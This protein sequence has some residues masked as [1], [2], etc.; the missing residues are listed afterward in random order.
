MNYYFYKSRKLMNISE[1]G[2]IQQSK[3][4]CNIPKAHKSEIDH[5]TVNDTTKSTIAWDNDIVFET[6]YP[7]IQTIQVNRQ[8]IIGNH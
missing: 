1:Q 8:Y 7:K 3:N 5:V 2:N 6:I 4:Q